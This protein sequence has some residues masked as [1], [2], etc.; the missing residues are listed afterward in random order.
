[1]RAQRRQGSSSG[2]YTDRANNGVC[3]PSI[4]KLMLSFLNTYKPYR[5]IP[6]GRLCAST[7]PHHAA[8]GTCQVTGCGSGACLPNSIANSLFVPA[9]FCK[10]ALPPAMSLANTYIVLVTRMEAVLCAA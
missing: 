4:A 6:R 10:G 5:Q 2:Y 1:M 9:S 7:W 3:S 8:G